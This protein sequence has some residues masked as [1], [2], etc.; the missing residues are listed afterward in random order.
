[1]VEEGKMEERE[2]VSINYLGLV[3][4]AK[5]CGSVGV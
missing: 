2:A 5:N 3:S 1:M 4:T